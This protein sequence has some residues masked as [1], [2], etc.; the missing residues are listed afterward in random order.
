MYA[1]EAGRRAVQ[2]FCETQNW[3]VTVTH[4]KHVGFYEVK[5]IPSIFEVRTDVGAYVKKEA[6]SGKYASCFFNEEGLF[7][8]EGLNAHYSGYFH[9]GALT[10]EVFAA[11]LGKTVFRSQIKQQVLAEITANSFGKI[12]TVDEL[13][14]LEKECGF[15]VMNLEQFDFS[16]EELLDMS[17]KVSGKLRSM[18]YRSIYIAT[19]QW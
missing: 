19:I 14:V 11:N 5:Y 8:F 1:Y 3:N 15:Q 6:K 4:S 18:G 12:Q 7:P 2:D 10:Q 9:R 13:H 17:I 16:E